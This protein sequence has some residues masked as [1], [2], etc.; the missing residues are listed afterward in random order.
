MD[1]E[2][3][4]LRQQLA[5]LQAERA[6]LAEELM[7]LAGRMPEI[8]RAFGNPF[9]YSH[10]EEPD[11]GIAHYTGNSSFEISAPTFWELKRVDRA[12]ARINDE[13]RRFESTT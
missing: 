9:Y 8:R 5:A 12:L 2:E 3:N 4:R 11:E 1:D 7:H 10:P 13:L 6:A